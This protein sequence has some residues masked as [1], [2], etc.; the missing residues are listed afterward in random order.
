MAAGGAA[1][2]F[3]PEQESSPV[4]SAKGFDIYKA[5]FAKPYSLTARAPARR[6]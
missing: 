1:Q 5:Q 3:P 4:Q 6:S 2:L